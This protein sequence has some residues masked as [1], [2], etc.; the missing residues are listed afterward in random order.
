MTSPSEFTRECGN[1]F[2]LV[3]VVAVGTLTP[4]INHEALAHPSNPFECIFFRQTLT[5]W[6]RIHWMASARLKPSTRFHCYSPLISDFSS[7]GAATQVCA[8]L[9][10]ADSS[11][12]FPEFVPKECLRNQ[13]LPPPQLSGC[14]KTGEEK[15]FLFPR[16]LSPLPFRG[17]S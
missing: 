9:L 17:P 3:L 11:M 15:V 8:L 10:Q 14:S 13:S 12:T 6:P 1:S 4:N 2:K 7:K 5:E 16:P